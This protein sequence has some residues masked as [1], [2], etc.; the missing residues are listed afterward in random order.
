MLQRNKRRLI[1]KLQK[2]L[3]KKKRTTSPRKAKNL[4]RKPSQEKPKRPQRKEKG[5]QSL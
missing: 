2:R 3:S 5:K 1:G 4:L